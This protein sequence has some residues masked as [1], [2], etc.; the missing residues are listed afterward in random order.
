M[1]GP[2]ASRLPAGTYR[3]TIQAEG[4][5]PAETRILVP[6]GGTV[7]VEIALERP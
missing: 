1:R 2:L 3:A 4:F 7:H 6:P 5:A